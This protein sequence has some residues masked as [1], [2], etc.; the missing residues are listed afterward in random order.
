MYK[1]QRE[2]RAIWEYFATASMPN[3]EQALAVLDALAQAPEGL[4]I[5]ALEARVQLRRS[6]L[7]L[8]PKV[9]DVEGAVV[10]EGN[11][12]RRTSSPWRY[13]NARYAAVA[14]AR[15]LE[16]NAM[17]EYEC[18]SQCRMLFLAQQLDDASAVACGRCDV[19]AG[20]WYL[21]LIHI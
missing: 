2:D 17:L 21:S 1:R 12:W 5:T 3:E 10:K 4:S 9:L 8:L 13:D 7:E 15:V 6:T 18:T 11:Y 16:Q 14:Q 20:P 19:C